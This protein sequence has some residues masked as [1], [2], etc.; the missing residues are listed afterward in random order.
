MDLFLNPHKIPDGKYWGLMSMLNTNGGLAFLP[1]TC[2][3]LMCGHLGQDIALN[4]R[5]S[6]VPTRT[7]DG[8]IA[9]KSPAIVFWN[10]KKGVDYVD[11]ATTIAR[12]HDATHMLCEK[13]GL[14]LP[15]VQ[16]VE[17]THNVIVVFFDPWFM[18]S[19]VAF[20]SFLTFVRGA[21]RMQ[22]PTTSIYAFIEAMIVRSKRGD[23]ND[24]V[25]ILTAEKEN[26][27]TFLNKD[28][29]YLKMGYNDWLLKRDP[30]NT[31]QYTVLAWSGIV[32][33]TLTIAHPKRECFTVEEVEGRYGKWVLNPIPPGEMYSGWNGSYMMTPAEMDAQF[34]VAVPVGATS[35]R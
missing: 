11:R 12:I 2:K 15:I 21:A 5:S 24:A 20:H 17:N 34:K 22:T 23:C 32:G 19:S 1:Q 26:L 28:F 13:M 7:F 9:Q 33:Y 16:P 30:Y 18:S 3:E 29:E 10:A 35:A 25:H 6:Q 4:M 27:Y 8:R 14:G 31:K